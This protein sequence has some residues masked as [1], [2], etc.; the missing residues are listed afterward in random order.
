MIGHAAMSAAAVGAILCASA[1]SVACAGDE[2]GQKGDTLR[3]PVA[4]AP[5][6]AE[7]PLPPDQL[8]PALALS[9]RGAPAGS[10]VT[11]SIGGLTLHAK[12]DVGFGTFAEQRILY[13]DTAT[14]DGAFKATVTIPA[15]A[16][17]GAYYFFLADTDSGRPFGRPQVFLVT[18]KDGTVT[19][20]GKR[21]AD[22][23]PCPALRTS[24]D[25]VFGLTGAN[26]APPVGVAM[27]VQG[28]I[29]EGSSCTQGITIA[30]SSIQ[31]K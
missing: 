29:V 13:H 12:V 27:T 3:T 25:E 20:T 31:A 8:R 14:V 26:D 16:R 24:T 22:G 28:T 21:T 11:V 2:T 9:P 5:A 6:S 7:L 10:K 15:D 30:V 23:G 18:T 19:L 4:S 1:A 17:P